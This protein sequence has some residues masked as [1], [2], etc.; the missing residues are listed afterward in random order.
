MAR[1][2]RSFSAIS[3]RI[4]KHQKACKVNAKPKKVKVAIGAGLSEAYAKLIAEGREEE[5]A[6]LLAGAC[7]ETCDRV[8][9]TAFAASQAET[10][11]GLCET[12]SGSGGSG[13]SR[14]GSLGTR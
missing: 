2:K 6:A 1:S 12:A 3:D 14:R 8:V 13:R 10:V 11:D 9:V 4:A 5:A 7:S